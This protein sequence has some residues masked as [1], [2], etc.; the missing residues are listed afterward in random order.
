MKQG[1]QMKGN[2][3]GKMKGNQEKRGKG[4][5]KNTKGCEDIKEM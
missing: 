4:R 1:E 2:E 5:P 3:R